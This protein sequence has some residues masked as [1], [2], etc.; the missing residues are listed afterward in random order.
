MTLKDIFVK[1]YGEDPA[2]FLLLMIGTNKRMYD[3]TTF[4]FVEVKKAG[5]P[6]Y[7]SIKQATHLV[8]FNPENE[9]VYLPLSVPVITE[10]TN[11]FLYAENLAEHISIRIYKCV[12]PYED[13]K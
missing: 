8:V 4:G 13:M 2:A 11:G 5:S 7:V 6:D 12:F 10:E 9:A 1:I 3:A